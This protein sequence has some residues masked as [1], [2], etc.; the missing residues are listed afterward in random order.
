MKSFFFI[1]LGLTFFSIC[2]SFSILFEGSTTLLQNWWYNISRESESLPFSPYKTRIISKSAVETK[3]ANQV[4][5]EDQHLFWK[6]S[7]ARFKPIINADGTVNAFTVVSKG[8]GYSGL[9]KA[10]VSGAGGNLFKLGIPTIINGTIHNLPIIKT[11]KW[12][13]Q[14]LVYKKGENYPYSGKV[15]SK[16]PSGQIIEQIPYLS[17][18]VHGTV[19]RWYEY[20]TPASSKDYLYGSKNGTHIYWFEQNNDPDD[21]RPSKSKTGEILPT[22]W[23]KIREE[24]KD[25]FKD[26]FGSHKA[27]EWVIFKYRSMGGDFPVRLLEH[28]RN[29]LRQGLF[30]GFDQFGNKTFKDEYNK[31]LRIKHKTFDKTKG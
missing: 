5:V 13:D 2:L 1:T 3:P 15:I 30:E 11:T 29:N 19:R 23:I 17:G 10:T 27:N 24:A 8:Q 16:F 20:G 18:K 7:G 6:G 28:W 14:P 4:V 9:V 31:G 22:L 12:N 26:N 21:F 25:K